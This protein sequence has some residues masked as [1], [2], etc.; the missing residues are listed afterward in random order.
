M[1]WTFNVL[2]DGRC[3]QYSS[4]VVDSC[5]YQLTTRRIGY[6]RQAEVGVEVVG[7]IVQMREAHNLFANS[8]WSQ[9]R[10]LL[11]RV[12]MMRRKSISDQRDVSDCEFGPEHY[13]RNIIDSESMKGFRNST[14]KEV[15]G[16]IAIV[17]NKVAAI[18]L[19]QHFPT[20]KEGMPLL[21]Y[22]LSNEKQEQ[23]GVPY[24]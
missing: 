15:G 13:Q 18:G 10:F 12:L 11:A 24:T 6:H 3:A 5:T 9:R 23:P 7:V 21:P 4:F 2:Y 1:L 17:R 20:T 8:R 19:P 14:D 16:R 22:H